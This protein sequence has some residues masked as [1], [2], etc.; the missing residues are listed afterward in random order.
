MRISP[1]GSRFLA[2]FEIGEVLPRAFVELARERGW[3]SGSVSGIG[4]V[5]NVLLAY[6]DLAAR[7]YLEFPVDGVVELVSLTG[8]LALV[9]GEPFWHLHAAVADREGNVKAGHLVHLEVA[10]TLECWI[11]PGAAL[12]ERTPD[13]H[14]G[15]NLLNL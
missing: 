14:T 4:G 11:E 10:V 13:Q 12:V 2:K 8:N 3:T 6:Y 9:N 7:K 15:L 5:R 1:Q